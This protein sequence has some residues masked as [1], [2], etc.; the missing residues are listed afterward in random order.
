MDFTKTGLHS[1]TICF[2]RIQSITN[3]IQ[4][5]LRRQKSSIEIGFIQYLKVKDGNIGTSLLEVW[6]RV[7]NKKGGWEEFTP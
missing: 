7:V 3:S 6:S 1:K 4:L 2:I 5:A